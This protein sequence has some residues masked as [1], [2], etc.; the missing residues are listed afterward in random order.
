MSA[1]YHRDEEGSADDQRTF[2][3]L[4]EDVETEDAWEIAS[5]RASVISRRPS[6]HSIRLPHVESSQPRPSPGEP[7]TGIGFGDGS[8]SV[9]ELLAGGESSGDAGSSDESPEPDHLTRIVT[10][11]PPPQG[12]STGAAV[13]EAVT[14]EDDL[15]GEIAE[16]GNPIGADISLSNEQYFARLNGAGSLQQ[17]LDLAEGIDP[18]SRRGSVQTGHAAEATVVEEGSGSRD[19]GMMYS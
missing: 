4:E 3:N 12:V 5:R 13:P 18:T 15:S 2:A 7:S 19:H 11:V 8:R 14:E 16:L 1:D 9:D 10:A 6:N 17:R